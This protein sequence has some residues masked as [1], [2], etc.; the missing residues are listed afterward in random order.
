MNFLKISIYVKLLKLMDTLNFLKISIY[1]KL[2]KL[3]DTFT[4][5]N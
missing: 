1:I 2:L 4:V 3:M 5:P